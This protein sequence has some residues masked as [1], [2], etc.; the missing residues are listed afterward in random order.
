MFMLSVG[1][2]RNGIDMFI[3]KAL[4]VEDV[5]CQ[6]AYPLGFDRFLSIKIDG[7]ASVASLLCWCSCLAESL[8]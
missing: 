1:I 8:C 3:A 7:I 6:N 2:A 5:P 4:V